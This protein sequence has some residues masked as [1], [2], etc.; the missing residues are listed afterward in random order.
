MEIEPT[1][2]ARIYA[3]FRGRSSK[4][5]TRRRRVLIVDRHGDAAGAQTLHPLL[6][7]KA[8]LMVVAADFLEVLGSADEVRPARVAVVLR[9]QRRV[10]GDVLPDP[11]HRR[12]AVLTFHGFHSGAEEVRQ[13]GIAAQLVPRSSV[14]SAWRCVGSVVSL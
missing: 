10:V 1:A 3:S 12:R 14:A 7:A 9:A 2:S 11:H 4:P 13:L 5:R 6:L 8:R